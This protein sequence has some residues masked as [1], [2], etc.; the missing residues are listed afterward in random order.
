MTLYVPHMCVVRSAVCNAWFER[1]PKHCRCDYVTLSLLCV[2]YEGNSS[3]RRKMVNER[4]RAAPQHGSDPIVNANISL[5]D[6][7]V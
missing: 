1:P 3:L 2:A 4:Q 7:S 6:C 5:C